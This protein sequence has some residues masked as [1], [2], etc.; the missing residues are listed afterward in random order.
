M[1][2]IIEII[3]TL[4][5][6]TGFD[7]TGLHIIGT[8]EADVLFGSRQGDFIDGRGGR[9]LIF[10]G[11]GDDFLQGGAG[12]DTIL[13][14]EGND[15]I[16]GGDGDDLLFGGPGDD[17][18]LGGPG[19]DTIFGGEG[20]DTILGGSGSDLLFGNEGQDVFV[21]DVED[22][23]DGSIDTI[24]DFELGEDKIIIAGITDDDHIGFDPITG[25]ISLNGNNII[26]VRGGEGTE[27]NIEE[28]DNGDYEI[29]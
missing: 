5:D 16:L 23:A 17:I 28:D 7:G 3:E 2:S 9:D 18:I 11:P 14:G 8:D 1:S 12:N 21:F 6:P 13:G 15:T 20:N 25:S 26:D 4:V 10:G 29:T 27:L 19:D 22:F 24:A